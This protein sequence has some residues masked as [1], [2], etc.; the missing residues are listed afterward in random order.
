EIILREQLKAIQKELGEGETGAEVDE[1]RDKLKALDLPE[2]VRK[3]VDRE[4][5]RL[6]RM[7]REGMESQVIRTYLETIAE[8][9][10]NV[11]SEEKLRPAQAG[12]HLPKERIR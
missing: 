6:G 2:T 1:L 12:P 11:R 8:L 10:W 9:P 4:L 3:E 5:G 7:G